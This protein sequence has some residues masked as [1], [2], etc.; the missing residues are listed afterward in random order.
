MDFM[1]IFGQKEATWNTIFSIF[2]RRRA[3]QTSRGPGKLS[4]LSSPLD[5]PDYGHHC[6]DY[7]Y[8][9]AAAAAAAATTTTTRTNTAATNTTY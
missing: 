3:S 5:G 7:D 4:P 9:G 1:H 2:E 8:D 6:Y